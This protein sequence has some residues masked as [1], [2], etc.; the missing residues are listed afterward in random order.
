MRYRCLLLVTSLLSCASTAAQGVVPS[1]GQGS[2]R[3]SPA[4]AATSAG[5]YRNALSTAASEAQ[6]FNFN[7]QAPKD[8]APAD[9]SPIRVIINNGHGAH[10]NCIP[11]GVTGACH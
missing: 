7:G 11:T 5:A 3:W 8:K 9:Q 1:A 6:R 10:V 4:P 2:D